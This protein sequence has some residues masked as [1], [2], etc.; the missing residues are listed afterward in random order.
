MEKVLLVKTYNHSQKEHLDADIEEMRGLI[1]TAGGEI[2][3][4]ATQAKNAIDPVFYIGKGKVHEIAEKYSKNV[5]LVVF[6]ANLKPVQIRNIEKIIEK[7]IIDRTQLILDIFAQRAHTREAILQVEY[8]Q[9]NYLL[10]RLTGHGVELSR[11]GGGI[12]T[13]GPGETKLEVDRRK[14]KKRIQKIKEE[15]EKIKEIRS[16]QRER[17][18]EIPVPLISI[19][20]YTNAGKTRLLNKLT[21]AGM[22]S[23]DKLFA[24]LDPK[25]KQYTLPNKYRVLFSDTVGFIKN[26]PP[27]LIAAFRATME[28][29]IEADIIIH[30]VD[31]SRSDYA[32]Q[33]ETVYEILK[34]IGAY[35]DKIIIDVYNKIDLFSEEAKRAMLMNK[36]TVYI[37]AATGEG[38]ETLVGKIGYLVEKEF[39]EKNIVIP[40]NKEKIVNM[41]YNEAVVLENKKTDEGTKLHIKCMKKTYEKY[42]KMLKEVQ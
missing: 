6:D 29:V 9:L 5:D 25:I 7:K 38:L 2:Y 17:R 4:I 35:E 8:A 3:A 15:L 37:S 36:S 26:L 13:R 22:L 12:G 24:T 42:Q 20:G 16:Q 28:E 18:K 1:S 30:L 27:Y 19:V 32:E 11:L 33:I 21:N 40:Y 34:D 10:P 39:I 31:I 41:F 23:E 14:I